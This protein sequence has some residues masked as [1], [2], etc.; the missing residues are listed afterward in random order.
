[1]LEIGMEIGNWGQSSLLTQVVSLSSMLAMA[2]QLP[3]QYEGAPW[4]E[5]EA[6]GPFRLHSG[7]LSSGKN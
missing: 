7:W 2:R 4:A 3:I 5:C 6:I 1:M